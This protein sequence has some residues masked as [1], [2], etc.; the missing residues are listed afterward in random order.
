MGETLRV[1][2]RASI[3]VDPAL[4][5]RFSADARLPRSVIA[6]RITSVFFQCSRAVV[7]ADLWNVARHLPR[8]ALPSTGTILADLSRSRFDGESYDRELDARVKA[9]LY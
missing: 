8:S 5:A 1:N 4:L 6:I 2:G 3:S 7:R 9:T